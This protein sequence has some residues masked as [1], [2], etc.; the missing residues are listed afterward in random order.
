MFVQFSEKSTF[1]VSADVSSRF[2]INLKPHNHDGRSEYFK[3]D[4][5]HPTHDL[6]EQRYFIYPQLTKSG[7]AFL[8]RKLAIEEYGVLPLDYIVEAQNSSNA[9]YFVNRAKYMLQ[10]ITL[11]NYSNFECCNQGDMDILHVHNIT[12]A[13]KYWTFDL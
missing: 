13:G 9:I 7:E 4:V 3:F 6:G 1:Y 11:E 2:Q 12:L 5:D 10:L 8:S